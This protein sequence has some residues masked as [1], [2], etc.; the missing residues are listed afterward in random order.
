MICA[1]VD[2]AKGYLVVEPSEIYPACTEFALVT[3]AD[4]YRYTY[5]ADLAIELD[6]SGTKLYPLLAAILLVFA[7]AWGIKQVA[8]LILNR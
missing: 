8:R 2:Q 6:P 5:W 3:S 4:M 7:T 1:S